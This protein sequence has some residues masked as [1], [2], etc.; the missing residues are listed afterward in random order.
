MKSFKL[1]IDEEKLSFDL[2]SAIEEYQKYY[3]DLS[4]WICANLAE[5]VK[6]VLLPYIE[7]NGKQ[8]TRYGQSVISKQDMLLYQ[9]MNVADDQDLNNALFEAI[10]ALNVEK[11]KG[12][13]NNII[14]ISESDYRRN[15][16][17]KCVIANYKSSLD[18]I[19]PKVKR[20]KVDENSDDEKLLLNTIYEITTHEDFDTLEGWC[21][22]IEYLRI[23]DVN[24]TLMARMTLLKEF[25]ETHAS[26]VLS[27]YEEL[28]IERLKNFNGCHRNDNKFSMTI[29]SGTKAPYTIKPI[30]WKCGYEMT[31]RCGRK[32]GKTTINVYGNKQLSSYDKSGSR[33]EKSDVINNMAHCI[34]FTYE[35]GSLYAIVSVNTD[36]TKNNFCIDEIENA[37]VVGVDVN[38]KHMLL[39]TNIV[40]N[41]AIEGYVNIYGELLKDKGF[42][43]AV[44]KNP[45][46]SLKTFEELAKF[47][48]F[49][50]IEAETL[51]LRAYGDDDVEKSIQVVLDKL[52]RKYQGVDTQKRNYIAFT[53]MLRSKLKS[54]FKL[55]KAYQKE[56]QA[57][58]L[59]MGYV[60]EST[61]SATTM[62][63][64]RFESVFKDTPQAIELNKKMSNIEQD[65]IGCRDNIIEYA[66][67]IFSMNG[68]KVLGLENLTSS[69]FEKFKLIPSTIS[70]L[71]YH[72]WKGKTLSEISMVEKEMK[73]YAKFGENY[74]L[75]MDDN[76]RIKDI[77]LTKNGTIAYDKPLFYNLILKK[78]NF[79]GIKDKFIQLSNN[80]KIGV[81]LVPAFYSSQMDSINHKMYVTNDEKKGTTKIIKKHM[82]RSKQEKHINGLNADFNAARNIAHMISDKDWREL[83]CTFKIYTPK[84][85]NR[86]GYGKPIM[87]S[88]TKNVYTMVNRIKKM[89]AI[90]VLASTFSQKQNLEPK[91]NICV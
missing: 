66:Y 30:D 74:E 34:T 13:N 50:P 70:L 88:S 79:A 10:S 1:K 65:I 45:Y 12:K 29:N 75:I 90:T 3:N 48:T 82:V 84:E 25:F 71:E 49:C 11:Y 61:K 46:L 56:Q 6:D 59:A 14:G 21:K 4:D 77:Q 22:Y 53:K 42:V 64:R 44:K 58:D 80:G 43:E 73:L 85:K 60:D 28:S 69:N 63:R 27:K 7:N 18:K 23:K 36:F 54:Y 89:N 35:N 9:F 87:T 5:P 20:S 17:V 62:D 39:A 47:V 76:Q 16:Y 26:E 51:Y 2:R 31:L 33:V 68:Y 57:Y 91:V 15:G 19:K 38:S 83:F 86:N 8:S 32:N 41:G 40:D 72:Q 81:V 37:K 67:R 78:V 55:Y 52:Q 24:E